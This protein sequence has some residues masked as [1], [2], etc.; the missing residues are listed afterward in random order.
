M[1]AEAKLVLS[2]RSMGNRYAAR[3]SNAQVEKI[4]LLAASGAA[5]AALA[6]RFGVAR[7]TINRIVNRKAFAALS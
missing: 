1:S 3:L 6:K 2:R 4:R 5:Q 7:P